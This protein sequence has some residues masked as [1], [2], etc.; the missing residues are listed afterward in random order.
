MSQLQGPVLVRQEAV[1]E[2]GRHICSME[3]MSVANV[4]LTACSQLIQA[5]MSAEVVFL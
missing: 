3:D 2:F 1:D 4:A 5:V